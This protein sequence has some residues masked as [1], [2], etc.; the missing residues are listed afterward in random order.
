MRFSTGGIVSTGVSLNYVKNSRQDF[1]ATIY[2]RTNDF[3]KL[4]VPSEAPPLF[5][6]AASN[7]NFEHIKSAILLYNKWINAK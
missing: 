2:G 5:I 6:F 7:D 4:K 1:I 3:A